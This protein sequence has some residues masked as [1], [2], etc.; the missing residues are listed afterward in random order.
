[1]SDPE[2]IIPDPSSFNKIVTNNTQSNTRTMKNQCDG[3]ARKLP[4][5]NGIHV[6]NT[7]TGWNRL[8]MAC[9]EKKYSLNKNNWIFNEK[10]QT[11]LQGTTNNG[12]GVFKD[13]KDDKWYGNLI[14][15]NI[16]IIQSFGPFENKED[17]IQTIIQEF[18][19]IEQVA[20]EI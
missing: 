9:D 14:H 20:Q 12:S 6:D 3:C 10:S 17:C 19:R 2:P 1:M 13:E 16:H 8:Y 11:W 15:P 5:E 7:Q 4:I 18:N